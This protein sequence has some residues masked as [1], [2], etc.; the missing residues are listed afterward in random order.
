MYDLKE[1]LKPWRVNTDAVRLQ[2]PL[3]QCCDQSHACAVTHGSADVERCYDVSYY[4]DEQVK[5]IGKAITEAADADADAD[6][7]AETNLIATSVS[8]MIALIEPEE[9]IV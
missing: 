3:R 9:A 5:A 8:D 6:A 4:D 7:D 2:H 1:I